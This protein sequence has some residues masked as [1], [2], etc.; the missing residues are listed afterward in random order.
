[1]DARRLRHGKGT[2]ASIPSSATAARARP[3]PT[4][5]PCPAAAFP[6]RQALRQVPKAAKMPP[7]AGVAGGG[8]G[9][10]T[11]APQQARLLKAVA[12][13]PRGVEGALSASLRALL[14][15][16]GQSFG[17]GGQG[18][19]GG[20]PWW[21][22]WAQ[23]PPVEGS[24]GSAAG[25]RRLVESFGRLVVGGAGHGDRGASWGGSGEE[26]ERKKKRGGGMAQGGEGQAAHSPPFPF[27]PLPAF[28]PQNKVARRLKSLHV[29]TSGL[30][31][32]AAAPRAHGHGRA[33]TSMGKGRSC[34]RLI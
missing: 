6:P 11:P 26:E 24:G 20:L 14:R 15:R 23:Q 22:G 8:G 31:E 5:L 21:E 30:G 32:R 34:W 1:M 33:G 18:G 3:Q 27:F 16:H 9:G 4:A 2:Y 29:V 13:N 19:Q 25:R 10:P 7:E 12:A 28:G 17:G